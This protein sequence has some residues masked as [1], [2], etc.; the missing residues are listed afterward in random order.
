MRYEIISEVKKENG[1]TTVLFASLIVILIGFIG[2]A[3][4]IGIVYMRRSDLGNLCQLIRD[5]RFTHQDSIR[6]ADNPGASTYEIVADAMKDNNFKGEIKVYFFEKKPEPNYR[7]YITRVELSED[8]PVY[9]LKLFGLKSFKIKA[10]ID[11]E[12]NYGEGNLDRIW[13]PAMPESAYNGLYFGSKSESYTFTAGEF[14]NGFVPNG[15]TP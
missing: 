5:D 3:I 6:F 2:M 10:Y 8:V 12:D 9:F 1:N 7:K 4:D 14:P 11:G 15:W 13:H